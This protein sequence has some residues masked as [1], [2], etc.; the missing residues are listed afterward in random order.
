MASLN[1]IPILIP[2]AL[3]ICME[4]TFWNISTHAGRDGNFVKLFKKSLALY[5]ESGTK[6]NTAAAIDMLR[7]DL[8]GDQVTEDFKEKYFKI[9]TEHYLGKF[10]CPFYTQH[11]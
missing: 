11:I 4:N 7:N 5:V 10:H 3:L 8:G 6:K 9:I 2:T 1:L